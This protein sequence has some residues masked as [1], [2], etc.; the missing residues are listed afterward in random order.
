MSAGDRF[1]LLEHEDLVIRRGVRSGVTMAVAIHSTALGPSLGGLRIWGYSSEREAVDDVLRLSRGMTFKAAAAG[2]ELGGG[3]GVICADSSTLAVADRAAVLDDFADLVEEL[4]GRYITAEDVG[5]S[6]ADMLAIAARTEHV[7]GLPA[8]TG[9]AGD[10]SPFTALGVESAMRACAADAFGDGDLRGLDVVVIGLGHVGARLAARLADAGARLTLSDIDPAKRSVAERLG[11]GWTEPAAAVA[12]PCD[13]LAPCAL[14]GFIDKRTVSALGSRIV[15]GAANNQLADDRLAE[16]LAE[17]EI[18]YAPDFIANA[19][20]L[21]SCFRELSGRDTEWADE[22]TRAIEASTGRILEA[23][24]ERGVTS[25]EAA[26]E[27]ANE[28][29]LGVVRH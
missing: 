12:I 8:S 26:F 7:V 21:I 11:A 29:L 10:P 25:L 20:G 13:V 1:G 24:R 4:D 17:R 22:K 23:A 6:S 3:K 18:I 2:L 28:R 14:G 19:G 5:T 16:V 15:C 27:L 9:G